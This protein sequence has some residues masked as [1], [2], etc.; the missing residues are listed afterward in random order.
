MMSLEVIHA[1]IGKQEYDKVK[2]LY[3]QQCVL[4]THLSL[5]YL[6]QKVLLLNINRFLLCIQYRHLKM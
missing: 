3:Q 2:R 1:V 4:S 6:T 5:R